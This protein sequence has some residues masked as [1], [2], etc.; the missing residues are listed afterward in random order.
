MTALKLSNVLETL[1][2]QGRCTADINLD[3]PG[4]HV[5]TF[6]GPANGGCVVARAVEVKTAVVIN[7]STLVTV[8]VID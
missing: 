7:C 1:W 3:P 5:Q 4:T 2:Y 6:N 8:I